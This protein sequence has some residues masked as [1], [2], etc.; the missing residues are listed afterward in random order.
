MRLLRAATSPTVLCDWRSKRLT[1]QND[2]TVKR[3]GTLDEWG[4]ILDG[5]FNVIKNL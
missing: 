2:A 4:K 5:L 3:Q 1:Q